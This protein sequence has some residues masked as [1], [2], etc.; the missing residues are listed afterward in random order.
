MKYAVKIFSAKC[1]LASS[2]KLLMHEAFL[3]FNVQG[4][5]IVLGLIF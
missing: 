2:L 1:V 4:K 3:K 5:E